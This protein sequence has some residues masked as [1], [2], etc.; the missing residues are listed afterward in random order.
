M[1]KVHCVCVRTKRSVAAYFITENEE[2]EETHFEEE[3]SKTL[4]ESQCFSF[5]LNEKPCGSNLQQKLK[6]TQLLV[7]AEREHSKLPTL[8]SQNWS[9]NVKYHTVGFGS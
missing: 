6:P 9:N 1:L 4:P 7:Y 5:I 8:R 3:P 2:G